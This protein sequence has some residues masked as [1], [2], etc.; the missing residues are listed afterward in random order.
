MDCGD[1]LGK[2]SLHL[3]KI[4]KYFVFL[5]MLQ[6]DLAL[7]VYGAVIVQSDVSGLLASVMLQKLMLARL[8]QPLARQG[9]SASKLV[10]LLLDS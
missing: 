7:C 6:R 8:G 2:L 9:V 3:L 5:G 1:L 4:P 10:F